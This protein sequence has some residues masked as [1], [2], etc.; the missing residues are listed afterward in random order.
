M[1]EVYGMTV[2]ASA[3]EVIGGQPIDKWKI[4]NQIGS[5]Y[6][7]SISP[8]RGA[9][10]SLIHRCMFY[11]PGIYITNNI[12]QK[13]GCS[14]FI[15]SLISAS[16]ATFHVSFFENIKTK[17]QLDIKP[18][19][20]MSHIRTYPAT[21]GREASFIVGLCTVTP[22][23]RDLIGLL[24]A[25]IVSSLISQVISQ[26]FDTIKTVQEHRDI[27]F[28]R[29]LESFKGDYKSLMKG[30]TPRCIRGIWTFFCMNLF[31][32]RIKSSGVSGDIET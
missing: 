32:D 4:K 1:K 28:M 12:A 20:N 7:S 16:F 27:G 31:L 2:I 30:V 17:M 24:P 11:M 9:Y 25:S 15:S 19:I 13:K 5:Q 14:P 26:P 23:L 3:C 10:V 6:V 18:K 8:W 22:M 21:F 29:A